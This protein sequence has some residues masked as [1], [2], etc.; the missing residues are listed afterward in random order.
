MNL[1]NSVLQTCDVF[2]DADGKE[3]RV[4]RKI[5]QEGVGQAYRCGDGRG[6]WVAVG[7]NTKMPARRFEKAD[8]AV[9][10]LLECAGVPL[11]DPGRLVDAKAEYE[12]LKRED[13]WPTMNHLFQNDELPA[14]PEAESAK[15]LKGVIV[16][17]GKA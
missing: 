13:A 7:F 4:V 14:I 5:N 10:Y 16:S 2:T 8:Q 11:D 9:S 12:H 6:G 17:I 15:P 3:L 1:L